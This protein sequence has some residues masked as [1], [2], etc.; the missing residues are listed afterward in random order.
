MIL[1][2]P[3]KVS[4]EK[5]TFDV[6]ELEP[7]LQPLP[8][9]VPPFPPCYCQFKTGEKMVIRPARAEELPDLIQAVKPLLDVDHDF[10]DVVGARVLAELLG[11]YR[12]RLK[13][14]YT[15]LGIVDGELAGF[16]NGRLFDE[17]VNISLHSLAFKRGL[18]I[19]ATMYYAKCEYCFDVIGQKE[20]WATYESYNGLKRWGIGMAQPSY[21][22]PEYQHELGGAKVFYI[23]KEYWEQAVKKYLQQMVGVEFI[24]PV[25]D[26]LMKKNEHFRVADEVM[27]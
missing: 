24:R 3:V 16:C 12:K 15:L 6:R 22:W 9:D 27:V 26:D 21:P 11:V 4:Q 14:A 23:T 18:R 7:L 2:P 19:G 20:F 10:Y 1:E 13:D 17:D 5:I 25:P 8:M